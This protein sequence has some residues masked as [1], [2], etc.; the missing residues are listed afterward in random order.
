M[1]GASNYETHKET[2][3]QAGLFISAAFQRLDQ[4]TSLQLQLD[5]SMN[6]LSRWKLI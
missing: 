1:N 2:R 6:P 3:T 4:F 5:M